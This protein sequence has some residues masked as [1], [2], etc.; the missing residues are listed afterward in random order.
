MDI[1]DFR[2]EPILDYNMNPMEAKAYKLML[3]WIHLSRKIFPNYVHCKLAK[4]KDPRKSIGFKYCFKLARETEGVIKDE[5]YMLSIRAQL[6]VLK[7][8]TVGDEH[9]LVNP[10]CLVGKKAW[11]RWQLWKNQYNKI[12]KT[13]QKNDFS[14]E[15]RKIFKELDKTFEFLN[16]I[17]GHKYTKEDIIAA[18][19]DGRISRWVNLNQV[20]PYYVILSP[21]IEG[22]LIKLNCDLVLYEKNINEEVKKYF[23]EKFILEQLKA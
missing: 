21:L 5:D 20:S 13:P 3:L 16:K 18:V 17:F 4:N 7:A 8:N 23:D 12:I 6:E 15:N 14:E 22:K 11:K 2:L 10:N 1:A 9:A 19:S